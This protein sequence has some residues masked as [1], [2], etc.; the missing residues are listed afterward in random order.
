MYRTTTD[1]RHAFHGAGSGRTGRQGVAGNWDGE[2]AA[3][4][5][6]RDLPHP[7]AEPAIAQGDVSPVREIEEIARPTEAGPAKPEP[8]RR[9][10]D[11]E[12]WPEACLVAAVRRDSPDALVLDVLVERYHETLCRR[13]WI[14][15]R[16]HD[17]AAE[18][19]QQTWLRV[20]RARHLLDPEGNFPGYLATIATNLWR[21]WRRS[22]LRAGPLGE[23][24]IS[25][26]EAPAAAQTGTPVALVEVLPDPRSMHHRERV[27]AKLDLDQALAK[28]PAHLHEV[29]VARFVAG[30]SCASIGVRYQRT[31]QAI[32]GW[33][34]EAVREM[35]RL[36]EEPA[37]LQE[38]LLRT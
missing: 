5:P 8:R 18:L 23:H 19:A 11:T 38:R 12:S 10:T 21:D 6:R 30:E 34:R 31:E 2:A 37:E 33:I 1:R 28:L 26:L 4:A 32:S 17:K 29:I 24:R 15:A 13:C 16:D 25:S 27:L 7:A 36:L 14:L 9:S 35:R 3:S 22:N 20:L